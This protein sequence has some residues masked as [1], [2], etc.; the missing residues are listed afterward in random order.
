MQNCMY[1]KCNK[2]KTKWKTNWAKSVIK[3]KGQL[4]RILFYFLLAEVPLWIRENVIK[5]CVVAQ[6]Q[7]LQQIRLKVL[8]TP[9]LTTMLVKYL[10]KSNIFRIFS[11]VRDK[12][13]SHL[14]LFKMFSNFVDFCPNLRI[15]CPFWHFLSLF[16]PSSDKSHACPYFLE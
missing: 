4:H 10:K 7:T 9:T 12:G 6:S 14:P 3:T 15:F 5:K 16:C 1:L 2:Q 8:L 11:I 13:R